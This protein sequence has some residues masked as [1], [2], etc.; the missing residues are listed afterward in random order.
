M[1]KDAEI[2]WEQKYW[3]DETGFMQGVSPLDTP[4]GMK[5]ERKIKA[6]YCEHCGEYLCGF[7]GTLET[8]WGF[9]I[10]LCGS[11]FLNNRNTRTAHALFKNILFSKPIMRVTCVGYGTKDID[12]IKVY[13]RC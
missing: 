6:N 7:T 4:V 10:H 11:C 2:I 8:K 5:E 12:G 1:I 9:R 3:V 13:V